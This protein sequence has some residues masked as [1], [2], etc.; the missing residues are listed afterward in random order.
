MPGDTEFKT[1]YKT[2]MEMV[3]HQKKNK[4]FT[5]LDRYTT[6]NVAQKK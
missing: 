6:E 4:R 1:L 5:P 2:D 3:A